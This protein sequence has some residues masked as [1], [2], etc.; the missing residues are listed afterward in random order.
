MLRHCDKRKSI[1]KRDIKV[2]FPIGIARQIQQNRTQF[3]ISN[4]RL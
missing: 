2:K 1:D 3:M 4:Y